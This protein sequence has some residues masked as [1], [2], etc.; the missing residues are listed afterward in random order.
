VRLWRVCRGP[1]SA[2]PL[3]GRGGLYAAGRWHLKGTRIVYTSASLALAAWEFFVHVDPDLAPSDLCRIELD[4]P[5]DLAV[6]QLGESALPPRW[7]NIPGPET[8]RRLGSDWVQRA[9]TPVL[10]VP[11]AVI[12]GESNYLVNPEHPEAVKIEVVGQSDFAFDPRALKRSD[13]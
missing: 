2:H 6:E 13:S 9:G 5:D 4:L 7:R 1:Y 11:S 12:P 10:K 3:D 8:L